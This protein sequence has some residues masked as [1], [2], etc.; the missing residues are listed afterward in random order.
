M[1]LIKHVLNKRLRDEL[2]AVLVYENE[3]IRASLRA[4]GAEAMIEAK[5]E[6]HRSLL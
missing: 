1:R 5:E 4:N 3:V 6:Q 2:D